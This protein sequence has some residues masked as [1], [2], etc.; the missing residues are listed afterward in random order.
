MSKIK[1]NVKSAALSLV[2]TSMLGSM[3]NQV[4][5]HGYM[6]S[7]MARQAFCELQQGYW[8]PED[9]SNIPNAA[10]RAAYLSSGHF[11]FVQLHEFAVNTR[12]YT[13]FVEVKANIPDGTLCAGGDVKK[14]G[15]NLPSPHW[16]RSDVVPNAN[17]DIKIKFLATTPHN[18]SFWEFY[19][20]QPSY[21]GDTMPLTW[22]D[23]LRV[24]THENIN[25][26]KDADGTRFYEMDVSIPADRIGDAILY[27]RWQRDDVVGEGFYNC[28]DVT[29]VRDTVEPDTWFS[30]GFFLK[31]GQTPTVGETASLRLFDASGQELINQ[32]LAITELNHATWASDFAQSL[33]I[34][35]SH[36]LNIG[37]ED[38]QGDIAFDT[39]N[40]LSNINYVTH[41]EH[42]VVLTIQ[43]APINTAPIVHDIAN[44]VMTESASASIHVHAFD[45]EQANLLFTWQ[46]PSELSYTGSDAN[47]VIT[48]AAV[49]TDTDFNLNVAV[50]DGLL[51]TI[52]TFTVTVKNSVVDPTVPLWTSTQA[53][54]AGDKVSYENKIYSAKWWNK[55]QAPNNSNAWQLD[56]PTDGGTATWNAQ[57][58]Y[59]QGAVVS[60][61][62]I[63][64]QAKWWTKGEQPDVSDV[65]QKR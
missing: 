47:L 33:N 9:G 51:T 26:I 35:Y 1:F 55:N 46:I 24:Q 49:D 22:S 65:W 62:Q 63:T 28:S 38:S 6:F 48:A 45:D 12:D 14:K 43:A 10:C 57:N 2:L 56:S 13:N 21:N 15:M 34:D 39:A 32:Q 7:P 58:E 16:Q 64:Y 41:N 23:V 8:W 53:Y 27:S 17:G 29:I 30:A 37:V 54:S 36:L 61:Q 31:Q 20:S 25:F 50:P 11:Q 18:P 40:L 4:S 44:I 5:A 52:K 42:T 60:Y 59:S 3:S 19:L